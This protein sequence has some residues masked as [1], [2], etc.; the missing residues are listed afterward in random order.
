MLP[1]WARVDLGVMAMKG[2]PAYLPIAGGRIKG[3]IPLLSVLVLRENVA[4]L[5]P[6]LEI[7]F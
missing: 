5:F 4:G 7:N 1:L 3:F 6:S 2:Y